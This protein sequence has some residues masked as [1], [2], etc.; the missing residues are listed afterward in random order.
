MVNAYI[1]LSKLNE[2]FEYI[3][4]AISLW[5][6]RLIKKAINSFNKVF[7]ER[8]FCITSIN[9]FVIIVSSSFLYE[10]YTV[11]L[12]YISIKIMKNLI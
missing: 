12:F 4:T 7:L 2:F 6:I 3:N 5:K 1:D 11:S 10:I 8:E 9:F